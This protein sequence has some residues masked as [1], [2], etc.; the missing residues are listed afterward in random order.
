[1]SPEWFDSDTYGGNYNGYSG[2]I[3]SLRLTLLELHM[4]HFPFLLPGQRLDW[5]TLMCTICFGESPS[6]PE[7]ASKEFQS[8]IECC[9]QKESNKRWKMAQLLTHLFVCKD[10]R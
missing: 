6:L 5:V 2:D 7:Q 8:F 10:P 3:W 4:G 9:L 1:M